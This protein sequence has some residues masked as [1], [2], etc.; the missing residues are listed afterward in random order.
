[1]FVV[2]QDD[3]VYR[4]EIFIPLHEGFECRDSLRAVGDQ[5]DYKL[6]D[7][8]QVFS[9]WLKER[10]NSGLPYFSGVVRPASALFAW[11]Q[12]GEMKVIAEENACLTVS[13]HR[14]F[15]QS[16]S[17]ADALAVIANLA[18]VLGTRFNQKRIYVFT[19]PGT[20]SVRQRLLIFQEPHTSTPTQIHQQ[21]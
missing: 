15:H 6:S 18:T 7:I 4:Y 10:G 11:K 1:M 21:G 12:L 9:E 20:S 14:E 13:S 19:S 5:A 17:E 8:A 3:L 2:V 16:M